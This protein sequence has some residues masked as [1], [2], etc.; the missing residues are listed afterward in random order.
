MYILV[1]RKSVHYLYKMEQRGE[2]WVGSRLPV[3]LSPLADLILIDTGKLDF[4]SGFVV[5]T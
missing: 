1:T 4:I 3:N 2:R 5:F